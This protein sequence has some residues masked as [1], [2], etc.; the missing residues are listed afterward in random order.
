MFRIQGKIPRK[1]TVACSGGVDSMAI[2]DFLSRSH[3]VTVAYFDHGTEHGTD[4]F[5][6]LKERYPNM[7]HAKIDRKKD[8]SESWEEY[9]R[10]ERYKFLHSIDG[11]VITGHHLDD[12]VETWIMSSLRGEGKLIPYCNRN[13]IRPFRLT[14][15]KDFVHWSL[16]KG[17][18]YID[19]E[20]NW[21]QDFDRNYIR[22]EMMPH[23]LRINPGIHKTI[24]KKLI[25]DF[26]NEQTT[27]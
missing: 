22:L 20:S 3:D 21:D 27:R 16:D 7:L 11:L 15:K 19:D 9:W 4:A 18:N 26:E 24:Y 5:E 10:T 14:K 17:I 25:K 8:Q 2:V 12:C 1:V 6:F 13:V 23:V